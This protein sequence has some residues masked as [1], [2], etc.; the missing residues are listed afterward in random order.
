MNYCVCLMQCALGR[1]PENQAV[2]ANEE[3]K[4]WVK[5]R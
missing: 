3:E 1:A 4:Y 2:K 5:K